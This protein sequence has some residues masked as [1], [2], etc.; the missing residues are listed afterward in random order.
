MA[1]AGGFQR[2]EMCGAFLKAF[3]SR[4]KSLSS[5]QTGVCKQ[6]FNIDSGDSGA[7]PSEGS[8]LKYRGLVLS[9]LEVLTT[10]KQ[11]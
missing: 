10:T 3:S 11:Y 2:C 8:M 1:A 5:K 6:L 4:A 7:L 9:N